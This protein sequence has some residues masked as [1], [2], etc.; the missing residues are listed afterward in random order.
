MPEQSETT[1]QMPSRTSLILE[2]LCRGPASVTN[3]ASHF[4]MHADAARSVLQDLELSGW[5]RRRSNLWEA[6]NVR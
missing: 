4:G 2:Y 5:A 1:G 6:V 3:V